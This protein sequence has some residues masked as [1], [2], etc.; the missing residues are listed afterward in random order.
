MALILDFSYVTIKNTKSHQWG[1]KGLEI[2]DKALFEKMFSISQEYP[3]IGKVASWF[4]SLSSRV[5]FLVYFFVGIYL[6]IMQD[7]KLL[8]F[9]LFPMIS[10]MTSYTFRNTIKRNRPYEEY[11]I[12]PFIEGKRK[13]KSYGMPSNHA[14]S[15]MIIGMACMYYNLP[16]GISLTFVS[17]LTGVSRVF[18]GVHYPFDILVGWAISL[19]YGSL[20]LYILL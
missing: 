14:S 20:M 7:S 9:L 2:M 4:A 3:F 15:S 12:K 16:L 6:G 1:R 17:I 5:Y 19:I 10:L 8:I 18:A 11:P 13:N